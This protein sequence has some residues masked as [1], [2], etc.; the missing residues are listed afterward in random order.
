MARRTWGRLQ[1]SWAKV[2]CRIIEEWLIAD[3]WKNWRRRAT[4][5]ATMAEVS[6]RR[7][8]RGISTTIKSCSLITLPP[9]SPSNPRKSQRNEVSRRKCTQVAAK[10]TRINLTTAWNQSKHVTVAQ[11]GLETRRR[12]APTSPP[13]STRWRGR[14]ITNPQAIRRRK[15]LKVATA[16]AAEADSRR[17]LAKRT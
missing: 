15:V 11:A 4:L 16:K 12:R 9:R 1:S 17:H 10:S 14:T 3:S 6:S 2:A 13:H 8:K 7:V 5:K